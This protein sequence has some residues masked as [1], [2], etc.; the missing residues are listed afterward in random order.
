MQRSQQGKIK[1]PPIRE[2]DDEGYDQY[3]NRF[4]NTSKPKRKKYNEDSDE[5]DGIGNQG[6]YNKKRLIQTQFTPLKRKKM[7]R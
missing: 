1:L 5:D 7:K 3:N 2:N 4:R 6:K